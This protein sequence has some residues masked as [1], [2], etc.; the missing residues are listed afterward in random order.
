ME[1]LM[2]EEFKLEAFELIYEAEDAILKIEAKE[3]FQNSFNIIF[4]CFH[5]IKGGAGMFGIKEVQ[6]FMHKN[7]NLIEKYKDEGDFPPDLINFLLHALDQVKFFFDSK[8]FNFNIGFKED[9]N[10]SEQ[11]NVVD[12]VEAKKKKK[13]KDNYDGLVYL[14]DDEKDI[15]DLLATVFEAETNYQVETFDNPEKAK[16]AFEKKNPDLVFTDL[17]MPQ[18]TG[19]ELIK[20]LSTINQLVPVIILSGFVTKESCMEALSYGA[21]GIL[22]KPC[23]MGLLIAQ[24]QHA[25][26]RYQSFKLFN[27]SIDL[28]TYQ[29]EEFD[30]FLGEKKKS[31]RDQFR[32]ELKTLLSKKKELYKKAA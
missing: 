16:A 25:I 21:S 6:E 18:M 29:F 32:R 1:E 31:E 17:S 2:E 3:D 14:V 7:E 10:F 15:L 5:S 26:H 28:L 4:R 24:A 13:L 30:K 27:R 20:E 9:K 23:D 22:E 12:V 19:M 8:K 11:N